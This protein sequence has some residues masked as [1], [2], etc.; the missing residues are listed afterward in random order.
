MKKV[1]RIIALIPILI[2]IILG[3]IIAVNNGKMPKNER[4]ILKNVF[5]IIQKQE[6]KITDLYIY[7]NSLNLSGNIINVSKDNFEGAKIVLTNGF[8]EKIYNLD[9]SIKDKTLYFKTSQINNSIML[10][11]LE[12]ENYYLLLRLKLNNSAKYRYYT[13]NYE[14]DIENL[15]YYTISKDGN[16]K[17]LSIEVSKKDYKKNTYNYISINMLQDKLPEEVYDIVI[18]A[19]HGGTDFGEKFGIYREADITLDYGVELEK[20]LLNK[21]LKVKLTRNLNNTKDYTSTNMYDEDGRIGIACNSKAKYMISLHVNND[22]KGTKGFEIYAPC[23]SDL[24]FAKLMSDKIK[25][26]TTL[27][28]SSNSDYKKQDGVYVKNFTKKLIEQYSINAEKK[29]Y[30]PYNITTDTPY[31]YT[32]REVGGIATNAYVDGRNTVYAA[33]KYY[34]SNIGIECYQIELGYIK[35]D[36]EKI[37]NEK[38]N[39]IK[40][41]GDAIIEKISLSEM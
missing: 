14:K 10:N 24:S 35:T 21:G 13:V 9:T 15:E 30:E 34:N 12:E 27:E 11:K 25:E 16:N 41:I 17:K 40:A 38:E 31:L 29:G 3:I 36:L 18:D 26:N 22:S 19:G 7:G 39:Y 2:G 32:I 8:E 28:Y 4:K 33:N 6:A 23:K 1:L 20:Y 37:I 5:G